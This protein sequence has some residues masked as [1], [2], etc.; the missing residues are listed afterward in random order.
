MDSPSLSVAKEKGALQQLLERELALSP[1]LPPAASLLS[2]PDDEQ[3]EVRGLKGGRA[4]AYLSAH[5]TPDESL[6]LPCLLKALS[7]HQD[8]LLLS[9]E[10]ILSLSTLLS[11]SPSASSLFASSP[12]SPTPPLSSLSF[13]S[14]SYR[15]YL[16]LLQELCQLYHPLGE[17]L[18]RG[19]R[20]ELV[21]D[22]NRRA[23]SSVLGSWREGEEPQLTAEDFGAW[24]LSVCVN[25]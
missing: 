14:L 10:H 24:F 4:R 5:R 19:Q 22:F 8:S 3:G 13:P 18:S 2:D 9:G 12:R 15:C 17:A 20:E 25:I 11:S 21:L 23:F 6:P 7:I 16:P 1:A